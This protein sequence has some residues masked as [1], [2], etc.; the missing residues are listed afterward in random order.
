MNIG[1]PKIFLYFGK[2]VFFAKAQKQYHSAAVTVEIQVRGVSSVL[3]LK[4]SS[5][6]KRNQEGITPLKKKMRTLPSG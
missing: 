3:T 1:Q 2:A 6:R 5:K 4:H